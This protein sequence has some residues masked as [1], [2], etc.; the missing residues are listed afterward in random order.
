VAA[1]AS[2]NGRIPQVEV[3]R[4]YRD[5]LKAAG[6]VV[7]LVTADDLD[8]V[9][10]VAEMRDKLHDALL[11][12]ELREQDNARLQDRVAYLEGELKRVEQHNLNLMK[13]NIVLRRKRCGGRALRRGAAL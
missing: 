8:R 1:R 9:E 2:L 6:K 5:R 12:L 7:K 11:K 4:A 13:D 3:Q 10:L